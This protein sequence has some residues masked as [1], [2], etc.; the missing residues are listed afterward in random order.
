MGVQKDTKTVLSSFI[1]S[2]LSSLSLFLCLNLCL[3]TSSCNLFSFDAD[4]NC[5]P[6]VYPGLITRNDGQNGGRGGLLLRNGVFKNG[7]SVTIKCMEQ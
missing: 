3:L 6:M 5:L 2:F 7:W 4:T 1:S